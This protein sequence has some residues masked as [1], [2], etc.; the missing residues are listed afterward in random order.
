MEYTGRPKAAYEHLKRA[1]DLAAAGMYR[2]E[3]DVS[4]K[5]AD[6]VLKVEGA[7]LPYANRSVDAAERAGDVY[8]LPQKLAVLAEV[9]ASNGRTND[10]DRSY[11]KAAKLIDDLLQT[12][13][14]AKDKST[15]IG[16]M[17]RAFVGHFE[18]SVLKLNDPAKAFHVLQTARARGLF[19]VIRGSQKGNVT[20]GSTINSTQ[21][22]SLQMRL[23]SESN[24]ATRRTLLDKLWETEV[25]LVQV[26]GSA[27]R[28]FIEAGTCAS[29]RSAIDYQAGRS[30]G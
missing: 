27:T 14:Y 12:V 6:V 24:P 4:T 13:P 20:L 3:S 19:E 1:A 26:P 9:Q 18:L 17:D 10:A 2:I 8:S 21:L 15:L 25:P 23:T 11:G 5:L 30:C 16:T 7:A 29:P 22:I 28:R